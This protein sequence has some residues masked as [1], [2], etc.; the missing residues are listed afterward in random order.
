VAGALKAK[1]LA[2]PGA[3]AQ[4][5]R[6]SSGNL[7]AYDAFLRG[8]FYAK[9]IAIVDENKAI[10]YYTDAVT[11][12]PHYARAWAGQAKARTILAGNFLSGLQRARELDKARAAIRT[13]LSLDPD[14]AAAHAVRAYLLWGTE[15][16]W[17]GAEAEAK[18]AVQLAPSDAEANRR[19]AQVLAALGKPRQAVDLLQK[20]L[21]TD[22]LCARCFVNMA[23]SL[24]SLG[25]FGESSQAISEASRLQPGDPNIL[26]WVVFDDVARGDAEA[27]LQAARAI[28]PGTW[29]DLA[30]AFALQLGPDRAAAD[31]ALQRV[32][33]TQAG[34]AAY[35]IAD[36]FALRKDP[37][38]MFAWLDRAW[39]NRDGGIGLMLTDPLVLRYR[40]D[41]RFVAFCRKVGLPATTDSKAMP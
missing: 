12:D 10:G 19:L 37:G 35:Q 7:A 16:D 4:S 20:V 24:E 22:P 2:V 34:I 11:L 41:P 33:D 32:I 13:A 21:T 18:R 28:A 15:L 27:A 40:A 38:A 8:E 26:W 14:L 9:R 6:P 36:I 3:V 30:M 31:A 1:L 17:K 23:A 25:H 5:D 39:N 29:R